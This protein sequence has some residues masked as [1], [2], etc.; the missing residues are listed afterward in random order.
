[1]ERSA[2]HHSPEYTEHFSHPKNVGAIEGGDGAVGTATVTVSECGDVMRLQ[3]EMDSRGR[4]ARAAFKTFGCSAAIAAGSVTTEWLKGKS[5]EQAED[6]RGEYV[7]ERLSL[8]P[9]KQHSSR[10]A[11]G[12]IREALADLR[13]RARPASGKGGRVCRSR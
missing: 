8:A 9:D 4:I 13:K 2:P 12:A 1:M 10:L 3:I 7:T 5:V 6:F 11:E